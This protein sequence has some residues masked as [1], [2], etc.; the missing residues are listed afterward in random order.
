VPFKSTDLHLLALDDA[1]QRFINGGDTPVLSEASHAPSVTSENVANGPGQSVT[2]D[3]KDSEAESSNLL[4]KSSSYLRSKFKLLKST[5]SLD[6]LKKPKSIDEIIPDVPSPPVELMKGKF[7]LDAA[8]SYKLSAFSQNKKNNQDRVSAQEALASAVTSP[9]SL[10]ESIRNKNQLTTVPSKISSTLSQNTAIS[11]PQYTN[12]SPQ[13]SASVSQCS[14][15]AAHAHIFANY[16]PQPLKYSPVATNNDTE[17][18]VDSQRLKKHNSSK[19]ISLPAVIMRHRSAS[20]AVTIDNSA[21]DIT[22]ITKADRRKSDPNMLPISGTFGRRARLFQTFVSGGG[23]K[24][25]RKSF[26]DS[27]L[28]EK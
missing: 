12:G 2:T 27:R 24:R 23:D 22:E 20:E 1:F 10:D 4:R 28:S 6:N 18:M 17:L 15:S 21:L 8:R 14:A 26:L 16:P 7:S 11:L 5:K 25:Y 13:L 9:P 19:R 3:G